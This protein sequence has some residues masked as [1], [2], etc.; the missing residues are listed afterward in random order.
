M[1]AWKPALVL[2]CTLLIACGAIVTVDR[3]Q[4]D[5]TAARDAEQQLVALRLDL[6]QVQDVPWGA[7]PEEGDNAA[8]VRGELEWRQAE[9]ERALA[10]LH[11]DGDLPEHERIAVPFERGMDALWKLLK[12][13]AGGRSEGTDRLSRIAA[14]QIAGADEALQKAAARYRG[15]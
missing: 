13:V 2:A 6:S 15:H 1:S 14:H 12:R 10:T 4:D 11:R 5:A 8:D 3:L 7:S 9:I